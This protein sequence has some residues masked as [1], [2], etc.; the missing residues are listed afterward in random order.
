MKRNQNVVICLGSSSY[1]QKYAQLLKAKNR[2]AKLLVIDKKSKPKSSLPD[3][4]IYFKVSTQKSLSKIVN[5]CVENKFSVTAVINRTD[6]FEKLHGQIVD[7]YNLPGPSEKAVE[8]LSD[9]M[10][11]HQVMMASNLEFYRPKTIF[12]KIDDVPNY[13]KNV[14]MPIIVKTKT[15]AKSR[16]VFT[17]NSLEEFQ[18][19]RPKLLKLT[20][21]TKKESVLI[22]EFIYGKQ[23]TSTVYVN[24]KGKVHNLALVD[25]VVGREVG[26][27]HMQL[28]YRSTPSRKKEIIRQKISFIMQK[29]VTAVGLKST[30]LHPEFFVIGSNIY[31]IEVNVRL[32][33]FR[34][35]LMKHAYNID[36]DLIVWELAHDLSVTDL[37]DASSSCT[38]CEVWEMESG[39]ISSIKI[40]KNKSLKSVAQRK[41][42]GDN[43]IAPPA[44]HQPIMHFTVV[45]DKDS[46]SVAK[47]I[48]KK[49]KINF[50]D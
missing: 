34:A 19:I 5:H 2:K 44:E 48:R 42:V 15:G 36:M 16:G 41:Y 38:V 27:D 50:E 9:K 20:K 14:Q 49:I 13:L 8:N 33:G 40:P 17:I 10:K 30:A 35:N 1:I 32:G 28:V 26:Q 7:T 4:A 25:V 29:I 43:Y 37:I 22:E 39:K 3:N 6:Y 21:N 47:N 46:L 31:L 24:S 23:V 45:T 11:M 12:A 18:I